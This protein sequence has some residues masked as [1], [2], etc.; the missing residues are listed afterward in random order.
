MQTEDTG[1]TGD[2]KPSFDHSPDGRSPGDLVRDIAADLSALVRK[3]IELARNEL[4]EIAR[5][6]LR[7]ITLAGLSILLAVLVMPLIIL[8]LR[9]VLDIWLPTWSATLIITVAVAAVAGVAFFKVRAKFRNGGKSAFVPERTID[10]MKEN[11]GWVRNR[12]K[13]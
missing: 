8:T 3:E 4:R 2:T 6:G 5:E 12:K 1:S 7:A 10:A 9:D 13:P 11:V